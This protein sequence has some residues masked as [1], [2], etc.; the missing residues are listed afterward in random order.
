MLRSFFLI[1]LPLA[2]GFLKLSQ[3]EYF[4]PLNVRVIL[5]DAIWIVLFLCIKILQ[6][7][8]ISV[9][10]YKHMLWSQ[11]PSWWLM[12]SSISCDLELKGQYSTLSLLLS[13]VTCA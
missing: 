6:W 4:L 8:S 9:G 13:S 5:L 7:H 12:G 1:A 3:W 2:M 11:E 10:E